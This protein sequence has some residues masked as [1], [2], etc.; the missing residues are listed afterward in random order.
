MKRVAALILALALLCALTACGK[1]VP[2]KGLLYGKYVC[3]MIR[4]GGEERGGNGEWLRLEPNGKGRLCMAEEVEI[5]WECTGMQEI[6]VTAPDRQYKGMLYPQEN[7]IM[8]PGGDGEMLFFSLN[9]RNDQATE[10]PTESS[11]LIPYTE[12]TETDAP[13]ER[14]VEPYHSA[15]EVV[16]AETE[17]LTFDGT[18]MEFR[19]PMIALKGEQ[20]DELMQMI[21]DYINRELYNTFYVGVYQEQV[22]DA[23]DQYGIPA[24]CSVDYVWGVSGRY[25][26]IVVT[27]TYYASS[28]ADFTVYNYDMATGEA[29]AS[30]EVMLHFGYTLDSFREKARDVMGSAL[31]DQYA[32]L[33]EE[34]QNDPEMKVE[35]DDLV[36][37]TTSDEYVAEAR[38]FV[39]EDGKLWMVAPIASFAGADRYDQIIP[40]EDYPIS[41]VYR[42][43]IVN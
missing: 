17:R 42:N 40:L 1:A 2:P 11:E 43:Y 25:L 21:V 10:L 35:F 19:I 12:P 5:A 7:E 20:P 32:S 13:T 33:L 34:A 24:F 14:P 31:F 23:I 41:E 29:A 30:I 38:P 18:E 26:S 9:G 3:Y 4:D 16:D 36:T 39:G 6:T 37:R 15:A 27:S 8:L 22:L 28:G